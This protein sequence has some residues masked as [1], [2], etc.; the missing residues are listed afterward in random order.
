M[1]E[2]AIVWDLETI[3]DLAAGARMLD[4]VAAPEAEVRAALARVKRDSNVTYRNQPP[5]SIFEGRPRIRQPNN[6]GEPLALA[7]R[8]RK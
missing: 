8:L 4:M 6:I 3:P 1:T 5:S 7:E 2:H